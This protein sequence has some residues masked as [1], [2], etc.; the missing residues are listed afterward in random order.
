M[1]IRKNQDEQAQSWKQH[2]KPKMFL[3]GPPQVQI[4]DNVCGSVKLKFRNWVTNIG[5]LWSLVAKDINI[6]LVGHFL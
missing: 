1:I 4:L 2:G 5:F 6:W 3:E